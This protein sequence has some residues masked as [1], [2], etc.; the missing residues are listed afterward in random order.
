MLQ[1]Y[2][3][4]HLCFY[5]NIGFWSASCSVFFYMYSASI[6][7]EPTYTYLGVVEDMIFLYFTLLLGIHCL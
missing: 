5:D 1:I 3:K 4:K 7:L 6:S 2:A